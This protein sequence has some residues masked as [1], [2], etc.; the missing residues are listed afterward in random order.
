M[1]VLPGRS[2]SS[3]VTG[4]GV[5]APT[6]CVDPGLAGL[7]DLLAAAGR[8]DGRARL[9]L[10]PGGV[11]STV[12]SVDGPGGRWLAKTPLDRLAVAEYW[13]AD[14]SRAL[15]EAA[16]LHLLAGRLG[17][18]RV[19][20]LR[21]VDRERLVVGMEMIGPPAPTWK[22]RLLAGDVDAGIAA[23]I[24][25][26]AAA[27]HRRRVPPGLDGPAAARLYRQFRID[28]YYRTTATR[29]PELAG[30]LAA[31]VADTTDPG[32]PRVLVHG[33]LNPKN[34][35]ITAGGPVVVDWELAHAG[36]PAFDLA[37]PVAH[38]L[39]KAARVAGWD[40]PAAGR[41]VA[42]AGAL[43]DAYDGPAERSLAVRH[44]GG[45]MAARLYGK[46][47]VDYLAG[48]GARDRVMAAA[49]RALGPAADPGAVADLGPVVGVL[50]RSP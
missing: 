13:P 15:R 5:T 26:A 28:P 16:V 45:I 36:D 6:P 18:T 40:R 1:T 14:R 3:G 7:R 43:W 31:L 4:S 20:R 10:L 25:G 27:L 32:R 2:Y 39:L 37:M 21:F 17:P 9:R 30:P 44:V 8:I 12:A 41:L 42:A 35:L 34:V 23:T 24:G 47:P 19:P 49:R 29:V 46:S 22:D 38:L 50:L 11:S 33:D 48:P